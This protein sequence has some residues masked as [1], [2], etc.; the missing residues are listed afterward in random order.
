[1]NMS[2]K[3]K[4]T[5]EQSRKVEATVNTFSF[6]KYPK[7]LIVETVYNAIIWINCFPHNTSIHLT[8]SPLTIIT[9]S[10]IDY[11]K[12]CT[13]QFVINVQVHEPHNNALMPRTAGATAL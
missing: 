13:L 9:R 10:K 7:R 1:M 2:Q 11:K 12:L 5:S 8:L 6:D 3:L 4:D